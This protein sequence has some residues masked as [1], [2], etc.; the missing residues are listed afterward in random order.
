M[1]MDDTPAHKIVAYIPMTEEILRDSAL[2]FPGQGPRTRQVDPDGRWTVLW[3]N[4]YI[5]V[6]VFS[7]PAWAR[8]DPAPNFHIDLFP[9]AD[10]IG[11]ALRR[12][13]WFVADRVIGVWHMIRFG[14]EYFD[15][16]E[17]W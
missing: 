10:R 5:A 1:A 9:R 13:Y 16:E 3:M 17:R 15:Q 7:S 8:W 4:Q 11:R 2:L 6:S 14:P 12:A